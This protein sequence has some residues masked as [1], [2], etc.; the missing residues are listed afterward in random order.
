MRHSHRRYA[1]TSIGLLFLSS[2]FLTEILLRYY[3]QNAHRKMAIRYQNR[4][5]CTMR[6]TDTRLIYTYVPNTCE[7]NAKGYNDAEYDYEKDP[8]IY[9]IVIIGDSV[10]AGPSS[11]ENFGKILEKRLNTNSS[12]PEAA[13]RLRKNSSF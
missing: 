9:R 2:I 12:W 1:I 6:A 4:E 11:T 5:L 3:Y 10:A 13:I 7:A 8:A